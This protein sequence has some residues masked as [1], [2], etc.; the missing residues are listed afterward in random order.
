[1]NTLANWLGETRRRVGMLLRREQ[2]D[3]ELAEE[4]RL[5]RERHER[6]L[7]ASGVSAEEARCA[8]H[9][10]FGNATLLQEESREMWT[11]N[12]FE[13][14]L[15]DARYGLRM[16]R[17]NPGFTMVAVLTLAL[18]IG[19]NTAIFSVVDAVLLR[20]LPFADS[21]RLVSVAEVHQSTEGNRAGVT[22][23]NMTYA[24]FFDPTRNSRSL[25]Q[26]S[27]YR[28]WNFNL[29][30]GGEPENVEGSK[31]SPDFFSVLHAQPLLGR[32]FTPADDASGGDEVVVLSYGLWQRRFGGDPAIIGQTVK[33]NGEGHVVIG[34]M[35]AHFDFP[36]DSSLWA[37]LAPGRLAN[38]RGAHLLTVLARLKPGVS[39]QQAQAE[40]GAFA[41]GI[42]AANPG[43]DPGMGLNVGNLHDRMAAPVRQALIVLW[44]A[45]GC[46]LLI[47]C[48]NLTNLLL[49][50]GAS[51]ARE[52]AIRAAVGAGKWRLARQ[53]FTESLVLSIFGGAAGLLLAR[54]AIGLFLGSASVGVIRPNEVRLDPVVL[55]FTVA[56][57]LLVGMGIALVPVWQVFGAGFQQAL[58]SASRNSAGGK[59]HRVREF[60]VVS[61]IAA[62]LVLLAG[63]G[64]LVASFVSLLRVPTGFGSRNVLTMHLFLPTEEGKEG[65]AH[66]IAVL[67]S[68]LER[69]RATP[70]VE[71]VGLT[72]SLPLT[73]GPDTEFHIEGRALPKP[74]E[75]PLAD[76]Q[77]VDPDF[78]QTMGIPLLRGRWFSESDGPGFAQSN[79]YQ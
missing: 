9:R 51:R 12:S 79:D 15:Q 48:A 28:R 75:E 69:L 16:L 19:A 42:T 50:Q 5:H 39:L 31:V 78:F 76:I 32:T 3:R 40:M 70:G 27:A 59:Q 23:S 30:G 11:W 55:G 53:L 38:N 4:M 2:F 61:E 65:D 21:G 8:A 74:G 58:Q 71:S 52:L 18:G 25:G 10:Q 24:T 68:I 66:S 13:Q 35:P 72:N 44:C 14:L 67:R 36:Q 77:V 6:D 37:P 73:G 62:V 41:Q 60:L 57:T 49:A 54:W 47:A 34:V 26:I 29:T 22:T 17:K 56:V 20:P 43:A 7:I 64:L 46:V 33:V 63:A 1:M 45:V